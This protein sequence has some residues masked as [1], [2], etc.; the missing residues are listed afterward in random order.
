MSEVTITTRPNGPL[1]VSGPCTVLDPN[2]KAFDTGGRPVVA[3]CR[4]GQSANKPF[5]DGAHNACGFQA[6]EAAG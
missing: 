2:G 4:C 6:S 5:C 3:L 1:L